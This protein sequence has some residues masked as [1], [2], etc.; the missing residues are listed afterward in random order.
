MLSAALAVGLVGSAV[1][2]SVSSAKGPHRSANENAF[3]NSSSG[4]AEKA[5]IVHDESDC[6]TAPAVE[7]ASFDWGLDSGDACPHCGFKDTKV[8]PVV[9]DMPELLGPN[10]SA[11]VEVIKRKLGIN[12][13]RGSI[14]DD[15]ASHA[16]KLLHHESPA[17]L[18]SFDGVLQKLIGG[19]E[20][21]ATCEGQCQSSP[22]A[23]CDASG[24]AATC[25]ETCAGVCN[26]SHVTANPQAG[27]GIPAPGFETGMTRFV[28]WSAPPP[29]PNPTQTLREISPHLD[30]MANHLENADL[31]AEADA[32]RETAKV[33]RMKARELKTGST[34]AVLPPRYIQPVS[35]AIESGCECCKEHC[36]SECRCGKAEE[37]PE[38][39]PSEE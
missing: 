2:L 23:Q 29:Q 6:N 21:Q 24:C 35:V 33:L 8:T 37:A 38:S 22:L 34:A 27:F 39:K 7:Q 16:G 13:F 14:F 19:C 10:D 31:F 5:L 25:T 26:N 12:P 30:A 36:G 18:K 9:L 11:A 1:M 3:E 15:A 20:L 17:E 4:H 28:E 32:L